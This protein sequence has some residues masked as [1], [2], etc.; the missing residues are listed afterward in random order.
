MEHAG[1]APLTHRA[2]TTAPVSAASSLSASPLPRIAADALMH[3]RSLA[4]EMHPSGLAD[5]GLA[6]VLERDAAAYAES[7]GLHVGCHV[8]LPDGQRL[9]SEIEVTIYRIVTEALSNMARHAKARNASVLVQRRG[10]VILAIVEDDG[11]GF[12][13][14]SVLSAP[15]DRRFGLLSMEERARL[16]GGHVSFESSAGEGAT[17]VAEIPLPDIQAMPEVSPNANSHTDRG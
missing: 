13:T 14:A 15:P 7:H 17:V 5:L 1:P 4:F 12:D 2:V 9:P 6:A 10:A 3:V 11:V 16:L 8:A